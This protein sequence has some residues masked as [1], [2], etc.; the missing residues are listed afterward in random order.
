MFDE[1]VRLKREG[2]LGMSYNHRVG[3]N[4]SYEYSY[5]SEGV[6]KPSGTLNLLVSDVSNPV[7]TWLHL[8]TVKSG[9]RNS[10]EV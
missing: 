1:I 6:S 5:K 3:R 8:S 2:V 4:G 10:E 9:Q 7:D